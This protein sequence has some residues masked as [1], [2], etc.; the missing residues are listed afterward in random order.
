MTNIYKVR[1]LCYALRNF[2]ARQRIVRLG[3]VNQQVIALTRLMYY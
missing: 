1:S 3:S 2:V